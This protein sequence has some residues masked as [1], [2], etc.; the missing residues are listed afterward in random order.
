MIARPNRL[1][2]NRG[3][4]FFPNNNNELSFFSFLCPLP[5]LDTVEK[6][7]IDLVLFIR[8]KLFDWGMWL[9]K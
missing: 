6:I 8:K 1:E 2:D 7:E 9:R 3:G 4:I 5:I